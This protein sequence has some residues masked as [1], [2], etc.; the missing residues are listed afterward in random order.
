MEGHS[1][2]S[3]GRRGGNGRGVS[4]RHY[5]HAEIGRDVSSDV[6]PPGPPLTPSSSMSLENVVYV[7]DAATTATTALS[8]QAL[9]GH[10]DR[11]TTHLPTEHSPLLVSTSADRLGQGQGRATV[12]YSSEVLAAEAAK[13]IR[14]KEEMADLGKKGMMQRSSRSYDDH[15]I[16]IHYTVCTVTLCVKCCES[17]YPCARVFA[18]DVPAAANGVDQS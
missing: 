14:Q 1:T 2:N 5:H 13:R 3:N 6:S 9:V 17:R 16:D 8:T 12:S 15:T 18:R 10:D 11:M 7:V 4:Q